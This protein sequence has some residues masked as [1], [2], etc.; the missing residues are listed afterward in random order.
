MLKAKAMFASLI[1]ALL[2]GAFA[3]FAVMRL[4][5]EVLESKTG[6]TI[7]D[8]NAQHEEKLASLRKAH[9]DA[10]DLQREDAKTQ[11]DQ[12]TATYEKAINE[13]R[14]RQSSLQTE[15]DAARSAADGLRHAAR[16]AA[17]HLNLPET[18]AVTVAE[19]AAAAN[20]LLIE[21]SEA[22]SSVAGEA[23][24]NANIVRMMHESWP[25]LE[26]AK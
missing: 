13:A 24:Y 23:V 11:Q 15:R 12:I 19:Y 7:A 8:L 9:Q 10:A 22:Y 1:A 6:K 4:R 18:P 21:C 14:T 2:V 20:E 3:S 17:G 26:L 25:V 5:M 16:A